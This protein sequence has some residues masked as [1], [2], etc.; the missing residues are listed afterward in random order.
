VLATESSRPSKSASR[1]L[2]EGRSKDNDAFIR[3]ISLKCDDR[4][5]ITIVIPDNKKK[6]V[7]ALLDNNRRNKVEGVVLDEGRSGKWN[8]SFWD[9][10]LDE[11]FPLHGL[12]P[13]GKLMPT[14]MEQRCSPPSTPL[15]NFKCS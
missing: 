9:P 1:V 7:M 15:K 5:D 14:S 6:P 13:D 2:F 8:T 12:H 3:N 11:T 10:K 4:T